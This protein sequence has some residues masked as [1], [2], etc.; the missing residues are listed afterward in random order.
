[1]FLLIIFLERFVRSALKYT[2]NQVLVRLLQLLTFILLKDLVYLDDLAK[3][4]KVIFTIH[5][6]NSVEGVV[7]RVGG[8]GVKADYVF[9]LEFKKH[10]LFWP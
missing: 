10:A 5:K 8:G 2:L 7:I 9:V 4:H 6:F 1:M 3:L